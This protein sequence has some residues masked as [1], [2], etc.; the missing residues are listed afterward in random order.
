MAPGAPVDDPPAPI[1]QPLV[2]ERDEHL[3][4]RPRQ[5]F[6]QREP[7]PGPV[8]REPHPSHLP[9]DAVARLGF[10]GPHLL[11][12]GLASEFLPGDALREEF[13]LDD[14]LG[15]DPGVIRAGKPE[16]GVTLHPL[17][18]G[19]DIL[20]GEI[21]GMAHVEHTGDVGGRDDDR[22]RLPVRIHLGSERTRIVPDVVPTRFDVRWFVGRLHR[23]SA[24]RIRG[25]ADDR[26]G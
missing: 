3:A 14:D 8:G 24:R 20:N 26:A 10:P 23:A 22:E 4:D 18:P 15:R 2:V 19:D 17:A 7:F 13:A 6:V 1:D 21:Q 5:A 9:R 12:E 11:D 16:R 25:A